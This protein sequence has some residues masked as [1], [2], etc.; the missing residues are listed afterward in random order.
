M[1]WLGEESAHRRGSGD[2]STLARRRGEAHPHAHTARCNW[3][4]DK[5]TRLAARIGT[6]ISTGADPGMQPPR[7]PANCS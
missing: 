4:N 6:E 5:D 3:V 2:P 1:R 7:E